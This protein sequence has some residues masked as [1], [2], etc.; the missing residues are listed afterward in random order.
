MQQ[1]EKEKKLEKLERFGFKIDS[2]N[3]HT[4]Q[5]SVNDSS[6]KENDVPLQQR[7]IAA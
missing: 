2:K 1:K 7:E 6:D 3:D 5:Q 4:S